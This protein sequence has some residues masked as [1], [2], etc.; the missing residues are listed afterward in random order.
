[1]S[2][3][4][5]LQLQA[6]AMIAVA[7]LLSHLSKAGVAQDITPSWNYDG[8]LATGVFPAHDR[9]LITL[10]TWCRR[11]HRDHRVGHRDVATA[12]GAQRVW[13][14]A[15]TV[16]DVS[17]HISATVPLRTPANTARELVHS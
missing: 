12:A 16:D 11:L 6:A 2:Q 8:G 1:M 10:D 15:T 3:P 5:E 7:K 9:A 4:T 17:V 13:T 14:I